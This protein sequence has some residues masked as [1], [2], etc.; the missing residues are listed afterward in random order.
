MATVESLGMRTWQ[1]CW[2]MEREAQISRKSLKELLKMPKEPME[3]LKKL[4]DLKIKIIM[5]MVRILHW[6]V[7]QAIPV[8]AVL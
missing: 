7:K 6:G 1:C 2:S 8:L 4:I 3:R 5:M